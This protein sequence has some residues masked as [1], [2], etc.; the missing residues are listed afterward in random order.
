ML[1]LR[2]GARSNLTTLS[3]PGAFSLVSPIDPCS[4]IH[5]RSIFCFF[6]KVPN[7]RDLTFLNVMEL[8]R[9]QRAAHS[10]T[11]PPIRHSSSSHYTPRTKGVKLD[12][13]HISGLLVARVLLLLIRRWTDLPL[14]LQ[15]QQQ[16]LLPLLLF[17]RH[18]LLGRLPQ[19]QLLQVLRLLPRFLLRALHRLA[20]KC[21]A[22]I[23]ASL[24]TCNG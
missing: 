9:G 22:L 6:T 23:S 2:R 18:L 21:S 5:R 16:L 14:I 3:L 13:V 20:S 12:N 4:E 17:L 19:L 8:F 7:F 15:K 1:P 11:R 10:V 24:L